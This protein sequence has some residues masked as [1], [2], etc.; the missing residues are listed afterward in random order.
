V[1][2]AAREL[3]REIQRLFK[4]NLGGVFAAQ[5][6]AAWTSLAT[7]VSRTHR[8]G[9]FTP[10]LQPPVPELAQRHAQQLGGSRMSDRT[11][12]RAPEYQ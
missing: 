10:A 1:A 8:L 6:S 9:G 12:R 4:A 7:L 3:E 2:R 5:S 11:L